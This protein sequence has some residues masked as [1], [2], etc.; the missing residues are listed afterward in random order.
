MD[1]ISTGRV[2]TLLAEHILER[3]QSVKKT[4]FYFFFL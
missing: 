3:D 1:A 4:I 2:I